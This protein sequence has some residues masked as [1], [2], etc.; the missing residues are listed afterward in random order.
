M[1][2]FAVQTDSIKDQTRFE[3]AIAR[4]DAANSA[5]PNT[6][7]V[8]GVAQSRELV[9][10]RRMTVRLAQFAPTASEPLRLAAHSQ[11]ICRWAIPR[12][13]YPQGRT[14]YKRWRRRLAQF[15]AETAGQ[16]LADVGY[17]AAT[18]RRVQSLLR[19]ERLKLDTEAQCLEDVI[20][21][22][23]LEYYFADFARQHNPEKLAD[24]VRKTWR[25]MSERGHEAALALPFPPQIQSLL[26]EALS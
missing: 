4:F 12:S 2:T 9:Y 14:G 10:A 11:H 17:D 3:Q 15:H 13:D 18:I 5:D 22:V 21:L 19:K 20:W 16:I 25:K 24:I 8:D 6:E 7:L 1:Q 26:K 23:F